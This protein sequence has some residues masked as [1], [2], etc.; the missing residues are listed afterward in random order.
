MPYPEET[1]VTLMRRID[2]LERDNRKIKRVAAG[3]GLLLAASVLL[4]AKSERRVVEANRFVLQD[5][6]G[7]VRGEL[8]VDKNGAASLRLLGANGSITFQAPERRRLAP[9]TQ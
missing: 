3:L 4:A 1:E 5:E 8:A 6:K 7:Q 9:A 2:R